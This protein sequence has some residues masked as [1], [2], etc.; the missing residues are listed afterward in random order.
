MAMQAAVWDGIANEASGAAAILVAVAA[1]SFLYLGGDPT[2][3]VP[4]IGIPWRQL[5]QNRHLGGLVLAGRMFCTIAWHRVE[6]RFASSR[7]R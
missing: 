5:A 3:P 6:V 7:M 4:D 2:L 1:A